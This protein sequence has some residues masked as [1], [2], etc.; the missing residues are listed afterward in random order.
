MAQ[1]PEERRASQRE[2]QRARRA[3]DR[4]HDRAL[5][6]EWRA[7]NPDKERAQ[8]QRYT[9]RHLAEKRAHA[10]EV[11][12]NERGTERHRYHEKKWQEDTSK[13]R[14]WE[15]WTDA[16]LVIARDRTMT[17]YEAAKALGRTY[18]AV[19]QKRRQRWAPKPPTPWEQYQ[20]ERTEK[21]RANARERQR[22]C[23]QRRK[24][25]A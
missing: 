21:V 6:R 20:Q 2:R 1:T 19:A 10:A 22:K 14:C 18:N 24:A 3:A 12:A 11:R 17:V 5:R 8:R 25:N 13:G 15:R 4:E 9:E 16:E 23:Q 7:N